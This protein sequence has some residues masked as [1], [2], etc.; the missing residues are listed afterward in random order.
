MEQK[1]SDSVRELAKQLE[2]DREQWAGVN[3]ALE[4]RIKHFETEELKLRT[5]NGR[6]EERKA[7]LEAEQVQH[8]KQLAELLETNIRLNT[9]ICEL[10]ELQN[11]AEVNRTDRENEEIMELIEKITRLQMENTDLRDRN[12]EL[13]A[14]LDGLAG[15]LSI[16]KGR[17]SVGGESF[18]INSN[19]TG[20][21]DVNSEESEDSAG[22]MSLGSA[23]GLAGNNSAVATK[24]RGDSPSKSKI[25]EE[26]PRLGKVRRC[27]TETNSCDSG[28]GRGDQLSP[29]WAVPLNAELESHTS[30]IKER[31]EDGNVI[32]GDLKARVVELEMLLKEHQGGEQKMH[33]KGDEKCLNCQEMEST[34]DLM[35]KEFDNL[36][37]YW[38]GKL[39]EERLLFEEEQKVND[40]KFNDLLQKM[41]DYEE[42]FA[43]SM[44][45]EEEENCR[46]RLSPIQERDCLEQQYLD[47]EQELEELRVQHLRMVKEKNEEIKSLRAD[48]KNMQLPSIVA[49]DPFNM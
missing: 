21:S 8:Q 10:E 45:K 34:L 38:Q 16:I 35:R 32:V 7:T 41:L 48:V 43:S 18:K 29:D 14:E 46:K 9:E 20:N 31:V 22:E 12:D 2:Q 42:Q 17:K 26:S 47:L 39:N 37:D 15:E 27:S 36:E 4:A 33:V 1:H 6:L 19:T 24:R 11:K 5:E 44:K 3:A 25:A 40:D 13:C 23:G 30:H 49:A 28:G